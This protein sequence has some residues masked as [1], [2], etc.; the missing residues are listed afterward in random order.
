MTQLRIRLTERSGSGRQDRAAWTTRMAQRTPAPVL[1]NDGHLDT[2]PGEAEPQMAARLTSSVLVVARSAHLRERR[3]AWHHLDSL[4]RRPLRHP[5]GPQRSGA[6]TNGRSGAA[7]WSR[8][9]EARLRP[10][11]SRLVRWFWPTIVGVASETA[12]SETAMSESDQ[13]AAGLLF[14]KGPMP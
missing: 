8:S 6:P 13:K 7:S 10:G 11:P 9:S 5:F 3:S 14:R 4:P 1:R 2:D 12:M